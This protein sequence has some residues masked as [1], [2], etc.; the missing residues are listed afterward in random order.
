MQEWGGSGG[1]QPPGLGERQEAGV[2]TTP[3]LLQSL[4]E[5]KLRTQRDF[6]IAAASHPGAGVVAPGTK[7][8]KAGTPLKLGA[9]GYSVVQPG[10]EI[11]L[12]CQSA[13][14]TGEQIRGWRQ[15][16]V[17]TYRVQ[18]VMGDRYAISDIDEF[19]QV[20]FKPDAR[21]PFKALSTTQILMQAG[22]ST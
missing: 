4:D 20:T 14:A 12:I 16:T 2:V 7:W 13:A 6:A 10:D 3:G 1:A 15:A 18:F 17:E 19:G 5:P 8:V 22:R 9:D 11:D 21:G